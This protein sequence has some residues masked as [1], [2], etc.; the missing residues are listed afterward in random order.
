MLSQNKEVK[1]WRGEDKEGMRDKEVETRVV[2]P[3]EKTG[4]EEQERKSFP[5]PGATLT[6]SF[7]RP[8]S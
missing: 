6:R 1:S 3:L 2:N 7:P 5:S 4:C 8:D